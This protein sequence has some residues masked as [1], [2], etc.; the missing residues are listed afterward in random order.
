MNASL[1]ADA[2]PKYFYK[3]TSVET[4]RS[5]LKTRKLRWG[6]PDYFNRLNDAF[7]TPRKLRF[8]FTENELLK[9]YLGT[10]FDQ[11]EAGAVDLPD[12]D[13]QSRAALARARTV[14]ETSGK[15]FSEIGQALREKFGAG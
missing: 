13:E 14:V 9:E 15:T 11:I 8:G 7:D 5:V 3:Y 4:A 12:G 6:S 2:R 10:L 1:V